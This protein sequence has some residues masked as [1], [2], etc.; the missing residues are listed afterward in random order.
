MAAI[1][2]YFLQELPNRLP[3]GMFVSILGS[4]SF[5]I[6]EA[7]VLLFGNWKWMKIEATISQKNS[8][9][10]RWDFLWDEVLLGKVLRKTRTSWGK[11]NNKISKIRI[12]S[13]QWSRIWSISFEVANSSKVKMECCRCFYSRSVLLFLI[14]AFLM[15]YFVCWFF[16]GMKK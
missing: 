5:N 2:Y 4:F 13:F 1:Y 9:Y 6:Q 3:L 7:F 15:L 12:E 11:A 16:Q 8:C 14:F 10:V